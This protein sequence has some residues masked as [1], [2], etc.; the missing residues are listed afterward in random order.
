[1][2]ARVILLVT[3]GLLAALFWLTREEGV[4]LVPALAV[5]VMAGALR[6]WR[7][8]RSG[9]NRAPRALAGLARLP[10]I[11][12]AGLAA[13]LAVVAGL[14][15]RHYGTFMLNEFQTGS[16]PRA[17]GA[18]SRIQSGEWVRHV[19][20][21]D[22]ALQAAYSASAAARELQ[23]YFDGVSGQAWRQM[24]CNA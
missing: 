9:I 22:S 5:L 2:S 16:F 13:V 8:W 4:W 10:G 1:T 3:L 14:N 21:S 24:G 15:E 12:G 6:L 11:P 18:L 20:V 7:D 19:P 17:Y 23:P